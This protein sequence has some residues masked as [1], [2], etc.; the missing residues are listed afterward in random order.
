MAL[1]TKKKRPRKTEKK[2]F[3]SKARSSFVFKTM[4][5]APLTVAV[6]ALLAY[7]ANAGY[8][9]AVRGHYL[10]VKEVEITGLS[11]VREENVKKLMGSVLGRNTLE[12]DL[13]KIGDRIQAHPWIRNVEV[14]RELPSRLLIN[15]AER[16]P[17]AIADIGSMWLVDEDG[18]LLLKIESAAVWG[19]PVLT[20]IQA[21]EGEAALGATIDPDSVGVALSALSE[22][23]G[24]SLFGKNPIGGV[25]FSDGERLEIFFKDTPTRVLTLR[26]GWTDEAERLRVVDYILRKKEEPVKTI[27]LMFAD[28]VI[29][30]YPSA[31]AG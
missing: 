27:N 18:V 28:K 25:N 12:L 11:V 30:T 2:V 22:L 17:V 23:D 4:L 16:R 7:G 31:S 15:V 24:Y 1:S 21:P 10:D 3:K 26:N 13:E 29:V 20:G 6:M 8:E 9:A 19:L 14:R 5:W